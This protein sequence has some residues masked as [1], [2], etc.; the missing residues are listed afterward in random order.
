MIPIPID[1]LRLILKLVNKASL[2]KTCL[3]N[4]TCCSYSQD[5][6]YRDVQII[7]AHRGRQV[8]RTL[9]QSTYLARRVRSFDIRYHGL[10]SEGEVWQ[11]QK[12]LWNMINLRHLRFGYY[13][14]Y[15]V[16]DG[17]TF[18]LDSFENAYDS[19]EPL[20]RFLHSQ[21][22]LTK[23]E[24]SFIYRE[25]DNFPTLGATVLPNLTRIA[26]HFNLLQQLIPDRPVNEVI[27]YGG[28]DYRDS[29]NL[30]FF[31]LSTAPIQKLTINYSY[32]YSTPVTLLASIFPSLTHL[33]MDMPST[34]GQDGWVREPFFIYLIIVG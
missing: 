12:A 24:L 23:F 22:S 8:Y 30:S 25:H 2:A 3:V 17:R 20:H 5:F 7:D 33:R 15:S 21:P 14:D 9:V 31:A 32:L 28:V 29:V 13:K 4:K 11:L 16:L 27:A 10:I 34:D 18:T 19:F 1:V 6:L 26:T